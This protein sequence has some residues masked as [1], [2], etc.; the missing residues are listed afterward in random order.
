MNLETAAAEAALAR[1]PPRRFAA[2]DAAVKRIEE[3]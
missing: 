3:K 2:S 1:M